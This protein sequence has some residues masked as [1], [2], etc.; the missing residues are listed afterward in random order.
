MSLLRTSSARAER[1]GSF[2]RAAVP[3]RRMRLD[4]RLVGRQGALARSG[5]RCIS[6]S[7]RRSARIRRIRWPGSPRATRSTRRGVATPSRYSVPQLQTINPAA[8]ERIRLDNAALLAHRI[9]NTDLDVFDQVWVK[10]DGDLKK[11]IARII[12]LAKS[13]PK[14][15][16]GAMK[17]WVARREPGSATGGATAETQG[18]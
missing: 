16:F 5:R 10:E 11:T 6:A 12:E 4:A 18:R 17:D 3:R 14:D 8:L 1:R 9:Y 13:R 15:P 7:I 2:A